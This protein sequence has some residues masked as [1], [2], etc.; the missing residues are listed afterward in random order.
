M[1]RLVAIEER[2]ETTALTT[3]LPRT[4]RQKLALLRI[5]MELVPEPQRA[6]LRRLSELVGSAARNAQNNRESASEEANKLAA[7]LQLEW[8]AIVRREMS[9]LTLPRQSLTPQR[10]RQS[11]YP[12][13][14]YSRRYRS[15]GYRG[16]RN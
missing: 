11:Y 5:A 1:Q 9:E 13:D 6:P 8:P 15:R 7:S 4:A 16:Y 12:R 10:R 14:D 3:G 2:R